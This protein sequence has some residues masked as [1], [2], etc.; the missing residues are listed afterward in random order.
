MR[1]GSVFVL[2]VVWSPAKSQFVADERI[3]PDGCGTLPKG[4]L[5]NVR[6]VSRIMSYTAA[7]K[8]HL[9]NCSNPFFQ[10]TR[11]EIPVFPLHSLR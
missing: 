1:F 8:N 6:A 10:G 3:A 11:C 4:R 9:A 5:S 2:S 7:Q